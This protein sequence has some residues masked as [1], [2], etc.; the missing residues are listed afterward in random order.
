[1]IG[2][3][4]GAA[5]SIASG[6]AGGIKARKAARKAN[7]QLAKMEKDNQDWYNRRYN[8]D[9]TQTALAQNALAK[10]KDAVQEQVQQ[11]TGSSIVTGASGEDAARAKAAAN[12][13]ISDTMSNIVQEGEQR[14]QNVEQQYM[15]TKQSL[16]QQRY[17]AYTQQAANAQKAA[18]EGMKA[19]MSMMGGASGGVGSLF[20]NK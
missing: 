18:S 10:A 15:S 4:V 8:E 14:K 9:Y 1:M 11:A 6:I 17:Q 13:T 19:G 3:I 5:T 2:A 16:G 7:A 12:Q 20:K